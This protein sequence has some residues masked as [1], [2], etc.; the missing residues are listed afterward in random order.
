MTIVLVSLVVLGVFAAVGALWLWG[1]SA[2]CA[3][4]GV[5]LGNSDVRTPD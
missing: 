1:L 4:V 3:F 2:L 5:L